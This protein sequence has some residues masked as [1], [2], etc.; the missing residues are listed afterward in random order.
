[1]PSEGSQPRL[2]DGRLERGP[3]WIAVAVPLQIAGWN[4][5][6]RKISRQFSRNSISGSGAPD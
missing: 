4:S 1:M 5:L 6:V 2:V 3:A